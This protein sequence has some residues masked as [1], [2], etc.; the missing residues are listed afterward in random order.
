MENSKLQYVKTKEGK[1]YFIEGKD[2]MAKLKDA[3][4]QDVIAGSY[5]DITYDDNRGFILTAADNS[6]GYYFLNSKLV[7]PTV[8][9]STVTGEL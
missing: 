9:N 2:G 7:V 1:V 6:K 4:Q 3:N 8:L 5:T